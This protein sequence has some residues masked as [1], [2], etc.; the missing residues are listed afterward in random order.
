MRRACE[1]AGYSPGSGSWCEGHPIAVLARKDEAGRL[2]NSDRELA[3]GVLDQIVR[4]PKVRPTSRI[5]AA[6]TLLRACGEEIPPELEKLAS[7][8]VSAH[9]RKFDR[10]LGEMVEE[11]QS[12]ADALDDTEGYTPELPPEYQGNAA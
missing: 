12:T 4:S 3:L 9:V 5:K 1:L 7:V 10:R 8:L 6:A 2:L 11:L